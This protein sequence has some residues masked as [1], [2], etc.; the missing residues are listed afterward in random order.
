MT[1][2]EP[3]EKRCMAWLLLLWLLLLF[4][5]SRAHSQVPV[6][7]KVAGQAFSVKCQY[8]PTSGVYQKKSW[9]KERSPIKCARLISSSNPWT[10]IQVS[11]FSV[12]DDPSA[13]FFT[14]TMTALKEDDPGR[15]WCT[16]YHPAGI[17]IAMSSKFD[18]V[19]SPGSP[20]EGCWEQNPGDRHRYTQPPHWSIST[21]YKPAYLG[22]A[23]THQLSNRGHSSLP[24]GT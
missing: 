12:W 5:G 3:R 20:G 23:Q 18:L 21:S 24:R 14:V 8:P 4:S 7:Q 10:Q 2:Q 16:V 15:Y 1:H 19:V 9:C 17:S 11:R 13:G 22:D 6:V